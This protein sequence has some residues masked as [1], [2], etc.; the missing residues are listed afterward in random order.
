VLVGAAAGVDAV[1]RALDGATLAHVAAHGRFRVDNPLFSSLTLADGPLTVYDLESLGR[2]PR[3]LVL[4][5]CE[6]SLSDVRPGDEL[7]GLAAALFALGTTTVVGSVIA[8]PDAQTVPL[9]SAF[10]RHL[11]HGEAASTALARAQLDVSG[12]SSS[13]LPAAGSFVSMGGG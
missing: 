1:R 8:V 6:S 9:M 10:H 5:A 3:T 4:S 7:M 11:A 2:A 12:G 13:P